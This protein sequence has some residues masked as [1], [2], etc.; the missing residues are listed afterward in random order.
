MV[1][2]GED[3]D[4]GGSFVGESQNVRCIRRVTDGVQ[5]K[6]QWAEV[7]LFRVCVSYCCYFLLHSL[8]LELC[9]NLT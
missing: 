5:F 2:S 9:L 1:D 7:Q 6:I 8:W 4:C 3:P